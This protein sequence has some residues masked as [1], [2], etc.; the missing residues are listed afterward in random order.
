MGIE[1]FKIPGEEQILEAFWRKTADL[2]EHIKD[3]EKFKAEGVHR[4]ALEDP[5][6]AFS[7]QIEDLENHPFETPSGRI[8]IFSQRVAD[9]NSPSCPPIPK[10]L[11]HK[12]DR[13]DP[14]AAQYPLQLLTPHPRNRV[15]SEMYKVDWL[16]EVEPH[17]V[18]IHPQDASA[19]GIADGDQVRVFNDRGKVAITAFVTMRIKP[20]VVSIFEG[21]WYQPDQDGVD[22]GACANTLTRDEYSGGGAA[23]LNSSLVQVHKA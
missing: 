20:G 16:R 5:V 18:W 7:Q 21:A 1:G 4:V 19:R 15:H 17:C 9:M 23:V 14:L 8:E 13:G 11:P 22:Q 10:Y 6:V 3:F 12:E 2:S